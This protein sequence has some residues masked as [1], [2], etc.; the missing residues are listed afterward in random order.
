[1]MFLEGNA[2]RK[3]NANGDPMVIFKK[4][5]DHGLGMKAGESVVFNIPAGV[6]SFKANVAMDDASEVDTEQLQ[7]SVKLNECIIWQSKPLKKHESQMAHVGLP[8]KGKLTLLVEGPDGILAD[9]G[10]ARFSINDP[11]ICRD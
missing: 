9:W 1:M 6:N 11:D 2:V 10:G 7:F 4:Q 8:G 5:Y 3:L